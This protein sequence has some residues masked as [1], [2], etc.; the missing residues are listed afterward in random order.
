MYLAADPSSVGDLTAVFTLLGHNWVLGIVSL[1]VFWLLVTK[2]V[3]TSEAAAKLLGPVGRHLS[4]R[5]SSR[6]KKY[7]AQVAAEAKEMALELVPRVVPADYEMVK[8]QLR[9][10]IERVTDLEVE[11]AALRSFVIYDE[12]WH[13]TLVL[14]AAKQGVDIDFPA[15][16]T[17]L[18]FREKWRTGWR[19][20]SVDTGRPDPSP[21]SGLI[22]EV[23]DAA[24]R[25]AREE[26]GDGG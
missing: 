22:T 19:P 24:R 15:R 25:L 17:W 3:E 10:V 5:N 4:E 9:N 21:L 8:T 6:Q 11:N 18:E 16:L 13:F 7:H 2:L 26:K 20:H 14:T 23:G 1:L 12:E